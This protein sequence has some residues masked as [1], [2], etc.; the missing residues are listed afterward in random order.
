MPERDF[1]SLSSPAGTSPDRSCGERASPSSVCA[2]VK[3]G[4][5]LTPSPRAQ[6]RESRLTFPGCFLFTFFRGCAERGAAGEVGPRGRRGTNG[7]N[8]PNGWA[9]TALAAQ[10]RSVAVLATRLTGAER[11]GTRLR[12]LAVRRVPWLPDLPTAASSCPLQPT[13]VPPSRRVAALA[14]GSLAVASAAI[15]GDGRQRFLV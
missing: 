11:R 15:G 9:L 12:C 7:T 5:E 1:T 14:G 13:R 3:L 8:G 6:P 10:L 2:Q 4:G